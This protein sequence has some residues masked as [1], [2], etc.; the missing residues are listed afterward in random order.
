MFSNLDAP[1]SKAIVAQL[2]R[3]SQEPENQPIVAQEKGCLAGL[4]DYL[5]H[6]DTE[7]VLMAARTLEFL[8]SH[9][10]NKKI[11]KEL[12]GLLDTLNE[13]Y[14]SSSGADN[15]SVRT[16]ELTA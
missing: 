7:V 12:P 8:S 11:M 10:Q 9:P 15:I 3:L 6:L 5:R 4:V 14:A 13:T 1:N 16:K 2:L